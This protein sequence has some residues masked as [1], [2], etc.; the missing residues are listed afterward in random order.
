M[1]DEIESQEQGEAP[2]EV[3]QE[4]S[5]QGWVPKD[6]FR[7]EEKDWIDADTFVQRGREINPILRKHNAE[8][9]RELAHAKQDAQEAL[10]AAREFREFQK[11]N[12]EKK[13]QEYE[14]QLVSLRQAKKEA[15]TSGD[16]E[17]AVELD[18]AIDQVKE[19][20]DKLKAPV[21][22]PAAAKIDPEL[23]SWIE[24][25]QWYGKDSD[26]SVERTELAN[27]LAMAIRRKSPSLTGKAFL[28]ELDKSIDNKFDWR[29][30]RKEKPISPAEGASGSSRPSGTRGKG[31]SDLPADAKQA[32]DKFVKQKLMTREEY[33]KEYFE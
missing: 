33:V 9:K 10:Q 14:T 20:K 30:Q 21:A 27:G 4:A 26:E 11:E 16:G 19:D 24:Q 28:D 31:Y 29:G 13:K 2:N 1:A 25:N 5:S 18:E 17:R 7:G 23:A 8:L 22:A 6:K 32:C 15:I 3:E 12:F